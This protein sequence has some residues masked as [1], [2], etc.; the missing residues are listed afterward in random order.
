MDEALRFTDPVA[1]V[2]G[3][4]PSEAPRPMP[5]QPLT[6]FDEACRRAPLRRRRGRSSGWR[7]ILVLGASIALAAFAI[8]EMRL[9]LS[10]GHVTP[11]A[12]SVLVLFAINFTWISLPFVASVVGFARVLGRRR[13]ELPPLPLSTR[14]AILMPTYNEDC[15]RV[16]AVLEAMARDLVAQGEAHA[17]DVFW[18]SDSTNGDIALAEEEA[19]HVLRRRL[20]DGIDVFYRRRAE[21]VAHKP[22][23][24][25]DFCERW[26]G[27]YDHFVM[28]DADSLMDGVTLVQLVQRM[29]ADPDVGLIQTVPRLHRGATLLARAQQFAGRLYGSLLGDGLAW[30]TGDE[31]TYWGH[32]A[33]VRMEAFLSSAGLPVLP[34]QPPFGGAIRSHDFVEAA[35][36]RRRGWSVSIATDLEGS[37]EEGP[38]SLVDQASRDRR[39]CQGNL[40]HARVLTAKGLHWVHRLQFVMGMMSYLASPLWLL[41]VISAL[42]LG[43]QYEFARQQYFAQTPTLFPLWP[44]IDPARAIRLF[45]LTMGVLFGPKVLGWLAVVVRPRRWRAYGGVARLSVGCLLEMV[46][47]A[48]I[49]PVL[50]L[51]HCGLV[52]DVL[53]GRDSGWRPQ[54]REAAALPWRVAL[55]SH[56]WHVLAGLALALVAY[57]ISWQMLAWLSPAVVGMLLAVA[58]SKLVASERAG[59]A[60][61]RAGLLRT[62]EESQVP[63]ISLAVDEIVPLYREALGRTPRLADV[64]AD[65]DLLERHLALTDRAPARPGRSVDAVEAVAEKKIRIARDVDDAVALLTPEERGRVQAQRSLLGLLCALSVGSS[66]APG[67]STR[68]FDAATPA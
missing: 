51:I 68:P 63:A 26:G 8:D 49:A 43:V 55:R 18:I 41:F 64:V 15:V 20:G 25:R 17:F 7:R 23:N 53:R 3:G 21:N 28:L 4:M 40:Q 33:I 47:S 6:R 46:V 67:Q 5:S 2:S 62:P 39:W 37:Y 66:P 59:L 61:Q 48:L 44:R 58:L 19:V 36:L 50:A 30:W 22:G 57:E 9:A 42:V 52:A 10:V 1:R 12:I 38:S 27:A 45:A 32:N 14:T 31:A 16:A 13:R 35:L 34:G 24:V 54:Q 60:L 11:V 29:E 56:R 65:R